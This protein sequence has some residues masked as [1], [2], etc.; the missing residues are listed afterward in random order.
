MLY[1]P[2]SKYPKPPFERQKQPFPGLAGTMNPRPD[3][4]ETF[5]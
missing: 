3:H 5:L 2:T 1:D 4:G